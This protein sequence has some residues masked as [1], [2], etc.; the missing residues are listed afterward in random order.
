MISQR[1]GRPGLPLLHAQAENVCVREAR[2]FLKHF[3]SCQRHFFLLRNGVPVA[4]D[5]HRVRTTQ[6][7]SLLISRVQPSDEGPY[8]CNAYSGTNSVSANT[9]VKVIRKRPEGGRVVLRLRMVCGLK[10]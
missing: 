6:D 8:T 7:G 3:Q 2:V 9:E 1:T 5:G 4:T 10:I